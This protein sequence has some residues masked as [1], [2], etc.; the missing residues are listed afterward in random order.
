MR[1]SQRL[2]VIVDLKANQ[3]K[4]YLDALGVAQNNKQQKELQL[5]NLKDY[6]QDYLQK[7]EQTLKKGV[8]V[9]RL[10]EFRAFMEKMDKAVVGEEQLL[11]NIEQEIASLRKNWELAHVTTKNMQKVQNSAR[12]SELKEVEK[13]E[14]LEQ[15]ERAGRSSV[16]NG[17]N[18][19]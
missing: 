9:V 7:N 4:K 16:N 1:R 3:E 8:S 19:A 11:V 5:K 6:Q 18:S 15:D 10:M 12:M 14:Q 2:Q 13:K 17:I